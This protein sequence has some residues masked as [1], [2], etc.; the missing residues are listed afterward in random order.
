MRLVSSKKKEKGCLV[1]LELSW[2]HFFRCIQRIICNLPKRK[3]ENCSYHDSWLISYLHLWYPTYHS[4]FCVMEMEYWLFV[5]WKGNFWL[6]SSTKPGTRPNW[7]NNPTNITGKRNSV[8]IYV[9]TQ[10]SGTCWYFL[11]FKR[12]YNK[13]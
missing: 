13:K 5:L 4:Y 11:S 8:Q 9:Y 10:I 7:T 12:S 1:E 6:S 2:L 3:V